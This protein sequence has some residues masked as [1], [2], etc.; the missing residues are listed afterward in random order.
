MRRPFAPRCTP[1][2]V[3]FRLILSWPTDWEVFIFTQQSGE[4]GCA[5]RQETFTAPIVQLTF[6]EDAPEEQG[7]HII[8][9]QMHQ[10]VVESPV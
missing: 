1:V 10:Q 7:K 6:W 4:K 3:L 9:I 5:Y 8:S 2:Q